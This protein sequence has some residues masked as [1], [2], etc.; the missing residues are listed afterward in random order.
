MLLTMMEV[1]TEFNAT[2]VFRLFWGLSYTKKKA[3]QHIFLFLHLATASLDHEQSSRKERNRCLV[4]IS[5]FKPDDY[6]VY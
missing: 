4:C 6:Y 2:T 1:Q 5:P 3:L